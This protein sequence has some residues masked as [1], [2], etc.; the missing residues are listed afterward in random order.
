MNIYVAFDLSIKN[1]KK[2]KAITKDNKVFYNIKSDKGKI[3]D[4]NFLKSE[5]VFGNV[6]ASWITK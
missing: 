5:I 1:K 4:K 2:L 6:P 3:P